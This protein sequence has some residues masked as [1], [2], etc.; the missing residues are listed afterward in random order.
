MLDTEKLPFELFEE[1]EKLT[2]F[3]D[4]VSRLFI[5]GTF[6]VKTILQANYHPL[7]SFSL[8]EGAPPYKPSEIPIGMQYKHINKHIENFGRLI[9]S[10]PLNSIQKENIFIRMVE[11]V[12]P[13]DALIIIA[14]KDGKLSDLYP[15]ITYDLVKQTFPTLLEC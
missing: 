11:G 3:E 5:G 4:K 6:A 9:T 12:S 1:I 13:Q 8:P 7:I 2:K 15:S 10:S 14:A